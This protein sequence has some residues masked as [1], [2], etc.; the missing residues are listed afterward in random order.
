MWTRQASAAHIVT[1][2]LLIPFAYAGTGCDKKSGGD[3]KAGAPNTTKTGGAKSPAAKTAEAKA[4]AAKSG[5]GDAC[6]ELC[7]QTKEV[8]QVGCIEGQFEE[9]EFDMDADA[10]D[11]WENVVALG[12]D[13]CGHFAKC[14]KAE[15]F[16][17][18]H[19]RKVK[20]ACLK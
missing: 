1:C 16:K 7:S 10:C 11:E 9:L 15:G 17:A 20:A 12:G 18:E 8:G 3:D 6:T 13:S 2:A 4:A 5:G 19:C 14:R